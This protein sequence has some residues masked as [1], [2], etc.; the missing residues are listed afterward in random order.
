MPNQQLVDVLRAHLRRKLNQP[1]EAAWV[2]V[3]DALREIEPVLR[4]RDVV[5]LP[6]LISLVED[7]DLDVKTR[8]TVCWILGRVGVRSAT[9]ALV[10]VATAR[11]VELRIAAIRALGEL[12][13]TN[14]FGVLAAAAVADPAPEVRYAAVY[15]LQEFDSPQSAD[16][17]TAKLE[18]PDERPS[19]RGQAAESLASLAAGK[20]AV[21]ALRAAL[22]DPSAEVR[23]WCA[24]ALG[25]LG[26]SAVVND[27]R[28]LVNDTAVAGSFGRVGEEARKAIED[29][30][31]RVL[32]GAD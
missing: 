26:T 27:L 30:R 11:P 24:Y 5:D 23:L 28:R 29:I 3:N 22:A 15:S 16:L 7:A 21:P 18:D 19:I 9:T 2:L 31:R 8:S 1:D 10:R 20:Q 13:G 25:F 4:D 6:G 32:S 12:G 14:T 17:L